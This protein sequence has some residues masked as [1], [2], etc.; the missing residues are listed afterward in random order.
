ML[1]DS[2]EYPILN[3]KAPIDLEACYAAGM[4]RMSDLVDGK[5]YGGDCRNASVAKWNA[6]KQCFTYMRSKFGDVFPEDINP[7]ELDD[8]FDLFTA[9]E[10]V[11][12]TKSQRI[13]E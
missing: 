8:G 1:G 2:K 11:I 4:I 6:T 12:P 5:Y 10:E 9:F 7:P 3:L 13:I